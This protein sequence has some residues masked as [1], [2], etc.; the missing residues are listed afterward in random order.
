[1]TSALKKEDMKA[2]GLQIA[3][4]LIHEKEDKDLI[5]G[6]KTRTKPGRP[7]WDQV[8]S[9]NIQNSVAISNFRQK[10]LLHV[11]KIDKQIHAHKIQ[12]RVA[13]EKN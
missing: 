6:L 13:K 5:T 1:M 11:H 8:T 9:Y 10:T 2:L 3:L 7:D 12:L 4:E